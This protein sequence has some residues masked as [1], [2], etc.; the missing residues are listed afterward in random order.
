[1]SDLIAGWLGGVIG[2]GGPAITRLRHY[3][4]GREVF[5]PASFEGAYPWATHL[6]CHQQSLWVVS[7][8][9]L[10]TEKR[11][12]LIPTSRIV[13]VDT[14]TGWSTSPSVTVVSN[15]S[16]LAIGALQDFDLLVEA[17]HAWARRAPQI[18]AH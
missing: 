4:T 12:E 3:R 18:D 8:K 13:E 6:L 9:G 2:F 14:T 5:I 17:A 10:A 11:I 7:N 15:G 1:M 16:R